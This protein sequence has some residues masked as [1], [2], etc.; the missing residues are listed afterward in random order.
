[1]TLELL[2]LIFVYNTVLPV[3]NFIMFVAASLQNPSPTY[4]VLGKL[5]DLPRNQYNSEDFKIYINTN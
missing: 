2:T 3:S 5:S 1:M 4:L